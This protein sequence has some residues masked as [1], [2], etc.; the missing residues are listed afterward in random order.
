MVE[1]ADVSS[2]LAES[3]VDADPVTVLRRW[4]Q[5]GALWRVLATRSD[6]TVIGLYTCDGGEEAARLSCEPHTVAA[7]LQGRVSSEEPAR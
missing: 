4:E 2:E 7:F 5:A 3:A 6:V 1:D